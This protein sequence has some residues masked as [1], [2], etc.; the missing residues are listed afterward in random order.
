M[1]GRE[2]AAPVRVRHRQR[3]GGAAWSAV[4]QTEAPPRAGWLAARKFCSA[5][6]THAAGHATEPR[7]PRGFGDWFSDLLERL[8]LAMAV[9]GA[10][11]DPRYSILNRQRS[12]VLVFDECSRQPCLRSSRL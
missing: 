5:T 4:L 1:L 3:K 8:L 9:A 6:Y 12:M 2:S 10:D 11:D 7:H